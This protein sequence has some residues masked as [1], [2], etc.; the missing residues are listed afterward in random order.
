M[1]PGEAASTAS[2]NSSL[3]EIHRQAHCVIP[4]DFRL[5]GSPL[6]TSG[7][8]VVTSVQAPEYTLGELLNECPSSRMA[9]S[10]EDRQWLDSEPVGRET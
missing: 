2:R 6:S 4:A 8:L 5:T 1:P 7:K 10:E 9:L 3:R